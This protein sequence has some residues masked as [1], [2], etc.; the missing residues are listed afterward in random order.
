MHVQAVEDSLIDVEI[1][2][3]RNGQNGS[4][5]SV[6]LDADVVVFV[7]DDAQTVTQCSIVQC[8]KGSRYHNRY[9]V[10]A[11]NHVVRM[12]CAITGLVV[13]SSNSGRT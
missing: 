7:L 12:V 13:S 11:R 1:V 9:T 6:W 2:V 10:C 8:P 4:I 3:E 5:S